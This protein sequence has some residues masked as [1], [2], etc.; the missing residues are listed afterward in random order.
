MHPLEGVADNSQGGGDILTHSLC[1][2]TKHL[3]ASCCKCSGPVDIVRH[4]TQY[5]YQKICSSN[6][7][8]NDIHTALS[9]YQCHSPPPPPPRA[10]VGL[11]PFY[12]SFQY[13]IFPPWSIPPLSH[14]GGVGG[15]TLIGALWAHT[16]TYSN[17]DQVPYWLT[18]QKYLTEVLWGW[19]LWCC[20]NKCKR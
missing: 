14:G 15:V 2:V 3:P 17:S 16:I 20:I 11:W 5:H 12:I 7:H 6:A 8:W 4:D 13:K 10:I 18:Y 19:A 9:T 1:S